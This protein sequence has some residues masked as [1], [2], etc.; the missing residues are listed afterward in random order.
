MIKLKLLSLYEKIVFNKTFNLLK[1]NFF[2]L[3]WGILLSAISFTYPIC[4]MLLFIYII[5][6]FYHNKTIAFICLIVT[7][8]FI[9]LYIIRHNKKFIA[10]DIY[11]GIIIDKEKKSSYD[12]LVIKTKNYKVIINETS[13]NEFL[14][15][16]YIS[17]EGVI[18]SV[19]GERIPGDFNYK[20]YLFNNNIIGTIK[21]NKAQKLYRPLS[22]YLIKYYCEAYLEKFFSFK[23]RSFL[24]GLLLGDRSDFDP[25]FSTSLIDNGLIHLFAV[26]G[27]H[28]GLII[29]IFTF[30]F[31]KLKIKHIEGFLIIFLFLYLIVTAF[32]PSILRAVLMYYAS[33]INKK[34]NLKLTSLDVISIIFILLLLINPFYIHNMG[35]CLSFLLATMIIVISP[36]LKDLPSFIQVALISLFGMIISLPLTI[37]LNNE[38]NLLSFL[39]NILF[40]YLI[41]SIVM[42]V[43][44]VTFVFPPLQNIFILMMDSFSFLSHLMSK[45]VYIPYKA[46]AFKISSI[47]LYYSLIYSLILHFKKPKLRRLLISLIAILL[48]VVTQRAYFSAAG[49]VVF[50]DLY[51]GEAILIKEP[52]NGCCALIDTGV[53]KNNELSAYLKKQGLYKLDILFITHD[54]LDHMGEAKYLVDNFK[55]KNVITSPYS[56]LNYATQ[57]VR[58]GESI[59]C[60]NI[61][62]NILHPYYDEGNE[63]DNSLVIY[64]QINKRG[65]LFTG[66][67]SVNVE[68]KLPELKVD[69]LK[70]AHHGST[71]SSSLNFLKKQNPQYAII[72]VGQINRF[73]FPSQQAITNLQDV[74][75]TIYITSE[76]YTI[77]YRYNKNTEEIITLKKPSV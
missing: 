5:Y 13:G 28:I 48:L 3:A 41:S 75:A 53:G 20:E 22:I 68:E 61:V 38:V 24:K 47:I 58:A 2:L 54:H 29:G 1:N 67:I 15:G 4:F 19:D 77:I 65:F 69:F 18:A 27:L 45:I 10:Q 26:S 8:Q 76:H 39:S 60:G 23:A 74:G 70:V 16:D 59:S 34:L 9:I 62:F 44:L 6:L 55:I 33:L 7:T 35:F 50:L 42:P 63:N 32:S 64:A 36:Y 25:D 66:D 31:K 73:S 72:Q 11:S 49:E 57:V 46:G 37:S 52:F 71:T 56:S 14:V 17:V 43:A 12:K 30:L 21:T 40:I 51:D